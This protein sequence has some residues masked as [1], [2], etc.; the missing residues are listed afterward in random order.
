MDELARRLERARQH[1]EVGWDRDAARKGWVA[2]EQRRRR[3]LVARGALVTVAVVALG[4][5]GGRALWPGEG[6]PLAEGPAA[7]LY[8]DDGTTA[9]PLD[10]SASLR[11]VE[12]GPERTVVALERGGGYFS[13]AP[14]R[15][16]EFR[17]E[18]GDTR[19]TVL[20]TR[21][22]VERVG[23]Q[24]SVAVLRGRVEVEREGTRVVL[25][26]GEQRWFGAASDPVA[27]RP[28]PALDAIPPEPA[29]SPETAEAPRARRAPP[30]ERPPREDWRSLAESGEYAA[31]YALLTRTEVRDHPR[32]L[33][34][35]ADVA[36]LSGHPAESVRFLRRVT[37]GHP[38]DPR[39]ALASFTLGRVLLDAMNRPGDAAAAFAASRRMG[40][41][42]LAEDSLAREVEAR[43]RAGD[44]AGARARAEEYLARY[45]Q[46]R[47]MQ[48]VRR[49]GDLGEADD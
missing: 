11:V 37:E 32:D 36:R 24:V 49:Y 21:F 23:A 2:I 10:E 27:E 47:R 1:V 25:G 28:E 7:P 5:V 39:A 45:P 40:D 18:A 33:L 12:Q 9:M 19:V 34:L 22:T 6:D 15:A 20:G 48:A 14:D 38:G 43:S 13:V 17:V 35:A 30:R 41:G 31:S 8:F 46:G 26:A 16:R 4:V 29:P 42:S 3:R 44:H